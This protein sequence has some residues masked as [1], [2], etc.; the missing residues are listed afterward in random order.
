MLSDREVIERA[1]EWADDDALTLALLDL[2]SYDL[3]TSND[4]GCTICPMPMQG[5][6]EPNCPVGAVLTLLRKEYG[7]E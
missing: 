5:K 2:L 6:H 4:G 3:G 7:S 1:R